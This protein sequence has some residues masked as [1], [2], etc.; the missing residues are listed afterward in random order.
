MAGK[1]VKRNLTPLEF[2][3]AKKALVRT[4]PEVLEGARLYMVE[5][6]TMPKAATETKTH[7]QSIQRASSVIWKHHQ[8]LKGVPDGWQQITIIVPENRAKELLTE[9][10]DLFNAY[11]KTLTSDV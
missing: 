1:R 8:K 10:H 5:G 7:Q 4:A 2:D 9:S 6:Y 3:T 11:S